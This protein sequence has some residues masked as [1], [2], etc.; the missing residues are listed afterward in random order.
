MTEANLFDEISDQQLSLWRTTWLPVMQQIRQDFK[1]RQVPVDDWPEDLHWD[2]DSKLK[3]INGLLAYRT[4]S[5]V[6]EGRL[7]GLMIVDLT[8]SGRLVS[9]AGKPLVYVEFLATAPW[10]RKELTS[11]P[12]FRGVGSVLV[13][14]AIQLSLDE[15]FHG[16]IGLHSLP[17]ANDF[18]QNVCGLTLV[19]PDPQKQD[20]CYFEMTPDQAKRF[21]P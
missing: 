1:K 8:R 19:G 17:R 6:C 21:R 4:F 13:Y 3:D 18:Y 20:M 16:R 12:V 7:Q 15:Q 9:Q 14:V 10:N 2:W 5:V 11:S